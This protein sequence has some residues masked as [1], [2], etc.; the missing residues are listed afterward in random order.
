MLD[1]RHSTSGE[2]EARELDVLLGDEV[3]HPSR[4]L[5]VVQVCQLEVQVLVAE[6]EGNGIPS[7]AG[8]ARVRASPRLSSLL[9]KPLIA[10]ALPRSSWM[11]GRR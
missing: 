2:E 9:T 3:V 1:C 8:S 11:T 10:Q 5:D 6:K 4:G 7:T